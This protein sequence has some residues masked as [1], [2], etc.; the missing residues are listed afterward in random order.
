M[1]RATVIAIGLTGSTATADELKI[2]NWNIAN[3]ASEV[4]V[5]LRD[6]SHHRTEDDFLRVREI[7]A[8]AD[9]DIVALQEIGSIAA[10]AKA[11]GPEY[12]VIFESRC[13]S[14]ICSSD[15]G[16][17]Y[18]AIAY[19]HGLAVAEDPVKLDGLSIEHKDECTDPEEEGRFVRGGIGISLEHDGFP[20]KVVSVH[21]KASCADE[22]SHDAADR[23]DVQDDCEVLEQQINFLRQWMASEVMDGTTVVVAG[24]YNRKFLESGDRQIAAI[25]ELVPEVRIE[26]SVDSQCWPKNYPQSRGFRKGKFRNSFGHL[27]APDGSSFN[28]SPYMPS[29]IGSRDFFLIAGPASD[30]LGQ[31]EEILLRPAELV[32]DPEG[33][34]VSG[35]QRREIEEQ[36]ATFGVRFDEPGGYISTCEEPAE[37]ELPQPKPFLGGNTV[38]GF[39]NVYPSDHCPITIVLE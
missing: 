28:W 10:A 18:T 2:L 22:A 8:R 30:R 1:L 11:L 36:A 34:S 23:P 26:P 31:A 25:R 13:T 14:A 24:D 19:K 20:L 17:I 12:V 27:T 29:S 6:G 33:D 3:L 15:H 39:Q 7:I 5:S 32:H 37:G 16:D 9:P 38:L 4:G 21:L 35:V